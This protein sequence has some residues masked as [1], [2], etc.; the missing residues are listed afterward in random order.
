MMF[1]LMAVE[2]NDLDMVIKMT[3][4]AERKISQN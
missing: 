4:K 3:H 1:I 2:Y